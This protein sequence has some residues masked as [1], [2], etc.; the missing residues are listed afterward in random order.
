MTR[1]IAACVV[2]LGSAL[3]LAACGSNGSSPT[4]TS[5]SSSASPTGSPT[6]STSPSPTSTT[7][8]PTPSSV[9]RFVGDGLERPGFQDV[10]ASDASGNVIVGAVR[11]KSDVTGVDVGLVFST[12]AGDTWAWGGTLKLAGEQVPRGIMITPQGAVIVG[13]TR[14][15]EADP[16]AFIA[17][18]AA[19]DFDL[20]AVP[21]PAQFA[22]SV[23]L[24][25]IALV[26]G[27]WVI[28]GLGRDD[29]SFATLLWQS[30]DQGDTWKRK[31]VAL[32]EVMAPSQLAVGP[33]GAWNIVGATQKSA[34]WA[35]SEDQG[36]S[37]S[38]VQPAAFADGDN[39]TQF[40]M[41]ANNVVGVLGSQGDK[42]AVWAS[43]AQ[44]A[45][46]RVPLPDPSVQAIAFQGEDFVAAGSPGNDRIQF[47]SLEAG[48]WKETTSIPGTKGGIFLDQLISDGSGVVA[49][50]NTWTTESDRNI[51]IWKGTL[52]PPV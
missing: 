19:P 52:I 12:D 23:S 17:A 37:W 24:R 45:M 32:P 50:G 9:F 27:E 1:P 33:D 22:G 15:G 41:S 31:A 14:A 47:W 4:S 36:L 39:A 18:A 7:P 43:N 29:T 6:S 26:K 25:D 10:L 48:A 8:S 5:T 38:Y 49:I 40:I 46:T 30:S 2:V 51:G 21:L 44:G 20:F 16:E 42:V 13:E 28:V 3:V 34:A 35:R 11:T